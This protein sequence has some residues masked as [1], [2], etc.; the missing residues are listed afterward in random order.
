MKNTPNSELMDMFYL[1]AVIILII[2]V[3]FGQ[4]YNLF[5]SGVIVL[6]LLIY[7]SMSK[8]NY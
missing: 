1:I 5:I 7:D 8:H 3:C 4:I 2:G 6:L